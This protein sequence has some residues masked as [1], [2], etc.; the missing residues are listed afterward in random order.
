MPFVE[1]NFARQGFHL[2]T[3]VAREH[4]RADAHAVQ[5]LDRRRGRGARAVVGHREST[6]RAAL[7]AVGHRHRAVREGARFVEHHR[8]DVG[9]A[10]QMQA[11]FEEDAAPRGHADAAEIAQR[12]A[13]YQGAGAGSHQKHQCAIP[14]LRCGDAPVRAHG[15]QHRGHGGEQGGQRHHHGRVDAGDAR[16]HL[17]GGGFAFGGLFHQVHDAR[18][19]I[20]AVGF[21]HADAGC[22]VEGDDPGC[23]LVAGGETARCT[24]AR[25]GRCVGTQRGREQLPV[26]GH[27]RAAGYVQH[28]AGH[29][30]GRVDLV[31]RI[32]ALVHRRAVIGPQRRHRSDVGTGAPDGHALK[33]FAHQVEKHYAHGLR[34]VAE[35]ER[36][37]RGQEHEGELVEPA[38]AAHRFPRLAPHADRHTHVGRHVEQALPRSEGGHSVQEAP[39]GEGE[40]QTHSGAYPLAPSAFGLVI[41]IGPAAGIPAAG[42]AARRGGMGV[43]RARGCRGLPAA[44]GVVRCGRRKRG[45]MGEKR[46]DAER[47]RATFEQKRRV[48][49]RQGGHAVGKVPAAGRKGREGEERGHGQGE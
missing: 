4:H 38:A 23:Q 7:H 42:A 29:H 20:F 28:G 13:Q 45:V 19:G 24:L 43:R 17:F 32:V 12:H 11:S 8:V 6:R 31:Q 10:V 37:H 47:K 39:G 5:G 16:H 40:G 25:E 27:P 44:A 36:A 46:G 34:A 33:G 18:K 49:G 30:G 2:R 26:E 41:L 22:A 48:I 21:R 35:G 15:R 1:T 14:P 3:L 9:R